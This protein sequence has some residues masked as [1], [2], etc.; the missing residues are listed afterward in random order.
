MLRIQKLSRPTKRSGFALQP[1]KR[2]SMKG[3]LIVNQTSHVIYVDKFTQS[4]VKR[5]K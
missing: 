3:V 4:W 2:T 5:K 1:G